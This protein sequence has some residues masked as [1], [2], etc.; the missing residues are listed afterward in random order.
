M[1]LLCHPRRWRASDGALPRGCRG[2]GGRC[3]GLSCRV[4]R[5]SSCGFC[6]RYQ[7]AERLDRFFPIATIWSRRVRH[8][9]LYRNAYCRVR[10]AGW[11]R[12]DGRWD[13]KRSF[14]FALAGVR[15]AVGGT[16]RRQFLAR[17][18][19]DRCRSLALIGRAV[20]SGKAPTN[21]PAGRTHTGS[22]NAQRGVAMPPD[23][24]RKSA[25]KP[26]VVRPRC[27]S[28]WLVRPLFNLGWSGTIRTAPGPDNTGRDRWRF[29]AA[30]HSQPPSHAGPP[31]LVQD[32]E[33]RM[34]LG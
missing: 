17:T 7:V 21:S 20:G 24:V 28:P 3:G 23:L 12:G 32:P 1:V 25:I 33:A 16:Q 29:D 2:G 18:R 31:A 22:A 14:G 4:R 8:S 26:P 30:I 19:V 13:G 34:A 10:P 9:R 6:P 5:C 27:D 15:V 11:R